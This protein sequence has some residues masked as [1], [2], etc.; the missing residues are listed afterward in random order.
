MSHIALLRSSDA[1]S[2][3][4]GPDPAALAARI[5]DLCRSTGSL[6]FLVGVDEPRELGLYREGDDFSPPHALVMKGD[7][8]SDS[9]FLDATR[10]AQA[11]GSYADAACYKVEET[12]IKASPVRGQQ[13]QVP[14]I[15][16]LHPLFFHDDL[17]RSALLRSWR[18]IHADLAVRIHVGA[19]SYGQ[20]LVVDRLG[21]GAPYGGFSE[22]HFPSREALLSGYFESDRGRAEIRHDI[23]HFIRGIP[24]RLFATL[25]VYERP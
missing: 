16:M 10:L 11:A 13:G 20:M 24:P 7:F 5:F 14:G 3:G 23:R 15:H 6:S 9:A 1:G 8:D 2:A 18:E 21:E 4:D 25:H 17:P 12:L 22:F 19:E